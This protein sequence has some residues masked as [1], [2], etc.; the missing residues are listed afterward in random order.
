MRARGLGQRGHGREA[1]R[2]AVQGTGEGMRSGSLGGLAP[3][4]RALRPYGRGHP[5]G[6]PP[7]SPCGGRAPPPRPALGWEEEG[8]V[9]QVRD[10]AAASTSDACATLVTQAPYLPPSP[11]FTT[12]LVVALELALRERKQAWIPSCLSPRTPPIGGETWPAKA[13]PKG[14]APA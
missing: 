7:T 12:Q 5:C 3:G 6:A 9:R 10:T 14:K 2:G 8:E 11:P 13:L 4:A 1:E